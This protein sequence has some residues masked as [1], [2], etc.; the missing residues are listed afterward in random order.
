MKKGL[1][2]RHVPYEGIAGFREPIEAAGYDLDR[3][4]VTDPG[5]AKLDLTAPDL[6]ILMGGPMG[7][8]D[9]DLH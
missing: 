7:V 2:I 4:D 9:Q 5:F 6:V 8:N 3:F 1:I